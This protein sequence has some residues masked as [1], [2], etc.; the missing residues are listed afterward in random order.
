MDELD[1][2]VAV[3]RALEEAMRERGHANILVAGRTGV[4]TTFARPDEIHD[5]AAIADDLGLEHP[6]DVRSKAHRGQPGHQAVKPPR[7]GDGPQFR[8]GS[9]GRPTNSGKNRRAGTPRRRSGSV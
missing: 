4:G 1:F 7:T 3:K 9:S 8:G 6:F 5:V 2:G